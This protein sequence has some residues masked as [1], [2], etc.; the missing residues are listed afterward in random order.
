[1]NEKSDIPSSMFLVFHCLYVH[2]VLIYLHGQI[3]G[4]LSIHLT[5][6]NVKDTKFCVALAMQIC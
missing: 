3:S 6:L 2:Y 1:M 4:K 5:D